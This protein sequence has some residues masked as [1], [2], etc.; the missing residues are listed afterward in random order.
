MNGVN[1]AAENHKQV[2]GRIKSV[3]GETQLLVVDRES[4]DWHRTRSI[5]VKSSL[6]YI[7]RLSNTDHHRQTEDDTDDEEYIDTRLQVLPSSVKAAT[8]P[9][10]EK[11][12]VLQRAD[13]GVSEEV[14][15]EEEKE[16]E[17]EDVKDCP[18]PASTPAPGGLEL[19]LSVS[20]MK[21][22]LRRGRRAD[23]RREEGKRASGEWWQQ[24]RMI[25]TL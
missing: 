18:A 19:H 22:K 11:Q 24:Y 15:E 6:P 9:E 5:I 7:L 3:A 4:E 14:E 23:P 21:E 2:V 10:K 12:I 1:I 20:E 25:Q 16:E 8:S 13:S 17:E